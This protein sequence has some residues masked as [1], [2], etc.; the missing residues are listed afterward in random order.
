MTWDTLWWLILG[1]LLGWVALWFC[2]KLFLRDGDVAGIRAERELASSNNEL[3]LARDQVR[4]EVEKVTTLKS[5]LVASND[6][7]DVLRTE[8]A[9]IGNERSNTQKELQA[10]KDRIATLQR[11]IESSRKL[12]ADRAEEINR[13]KQSFIALENERDVAQRWAQGKE[14]ETAKL[15][16][17]TEQ[18]AQELIEA[19]RLLGQANH[20]IQA[21]QRTARLLEAQIGSNTRVTPQLHGKLR[22]RMKRL[23]GIQQTVDALT[24]ADDARRATARQN[25]EQGDT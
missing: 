18:H 23:A 2:D 16:E 5:D 14:S 25:S 8:L 21:A 4:R 22:G 3:D 24:A 7:A 1:S 20:H 11:E 10:E 6:Q 17:Q 15:N 12:A 19:R 13:M 9:L